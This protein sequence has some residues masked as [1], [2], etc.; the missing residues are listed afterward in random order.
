RSLWLTL[1]L[2]IP[3]LAQAQEPGDDLLLEDSTLDV[4]LRKERGGGL[5]LHTLG[6]GGQYRQGVARTALRKQFIEFDL[7]SMKSSKEIKTVNPYFSNSRSYVYGKMNSVLVARGGYSFHNR[8]SR[9][10]R[11]G[12]LE[13]RYILGAGASLAIAKPI[14]LNIIRFTSS[15][16]EYNITTER[17]DPEEHQVENIYGRASYFKGIEKSSFHPGAYARFGFTFDYGQEHT[18]V[19]SL[20]VGTLLDIYPFFPVE[21]MAFNPKHHYFVNF[22]L[23]I[24]IGQRYNRLPSKREKAAV[25]DQP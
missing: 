11:D 22:Y 9:K 2:L 3:F 17:Y 23:G 1:A 19:R 12:G 4:I 18:K 10:P 15:I 7:V 13:V 14:Y 8:L 21:I 16:Y 5:L 6:W 25:S 24:N 20:E